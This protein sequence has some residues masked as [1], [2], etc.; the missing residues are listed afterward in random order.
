MIPVVI[1]AGGMGTR[2]REETAV[3]P[4][5]MVE[6]GTRPILWHIMKIY[7]H[8]GYRRFAIP[9]GYKGHVIKEYFLGYRDRY[10]DF[11]V[12]LGD[13]VVAR[14]ADASEPWTI[15]VVETG[16]ATMTGGRIKRLAP[17]L[18][19]RFMVT[20]GDGVANV[21][22]EK[23]VRFHER[24]GRLA[25]V[26]A[27]RPPAR[28]GAMELHEDRV[29]SFSEKS[30]T[31]AGWIN[32]GFFVFERAVLDYIAGDDT[33]LEHE[34]LE[35]LAAE[36]ELMAFRHPGFWEPMDTQRD[37]DSLNRQ[38]ASGEAPWKVWND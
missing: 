34:P 23:L 27:V 25:T 35:R 18:D 1:L 20:Y 19:G 13:G 30:Q 26:T 8:Y 6:I 31:G 11:T 15:T 37:L 38:W 2:I 33:S 12:D 36:G 14:H 22:I 9:V 3:R 16:A 17:F 28:F 4:K 24:H 21:D 7:D 32:G 10:A 5:P 29:M